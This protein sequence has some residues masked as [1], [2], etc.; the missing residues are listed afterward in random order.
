MSP[1]NNNHFLEQ[2]RRMLQDIYINNIGTLLENQSNDPQ[3]N[4]LAQ[5]S[6]QN[7]METTVASLA[8]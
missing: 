7:N 3:K 5:D 1:E 4:Q 2:S 8:I 6:N